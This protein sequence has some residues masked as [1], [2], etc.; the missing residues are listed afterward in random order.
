ME[1]KNL[2]VVQC[3]KKNQILLLPLFIIRVAAKGFYRHRSRDHN[4]SILTDFFLQYSKELAVAGKYIKTLSS[5]LRSSV[6]NQ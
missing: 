6:K 4:R 5:E 3:E 1:K 2:H